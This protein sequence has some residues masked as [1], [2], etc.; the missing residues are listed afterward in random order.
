MKRGL[1]RATLA[2]EGPFGWE[3][4]IVLLGDVHMGI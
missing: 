1:V 3:L 2:G 4:L